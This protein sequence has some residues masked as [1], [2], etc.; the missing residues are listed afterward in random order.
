MAK[1]LLLVDDDPRILKV[2]SLSFKMLGYEVA[3][4]ADGEEAERVALAEQPDLIVLDVM[5]PKKDGFTVCRDLKVNPAFHQVPILLLTAKS[6]QA[7][8]YSGL[9]CGAD[10]Y[11]TKPYDARRLEALVAE[12]LEEAASGRPRVAWTGLPSGFQVEEE[13]Q[14]RLAAG[15]RPLLVELGLEAGPAEAFAR[16]L[17]RTQLRDLVRRLGWTL[18]ERLQETCPGAV[19]GQRPDDRFLLILGEGT[20]AATLAALLEALEDFLRESDSTGSLHL[21]WRALD[22]DAEA[23]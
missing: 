17:G 4:A 18:Y 15:G 3:Q 21:T 5:M 1:K 20:E 11:M 16:K 14:A 7:D 12:L 10:A 19:L 9:D 2:L 23:R 22:E 13:Y 6:E 8:V